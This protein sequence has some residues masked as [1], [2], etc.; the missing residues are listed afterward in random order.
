MLTHLETLI[1]GVI[2]SA[3]CRAFGDE[4]AAAFLEIR[5]TDRPEFG[6]YT[7]NIAMLAA[8]KLRAS[9]RDIGGRL[10]SALTDQIETDPSH[11]VARVELAGPGF[12]NLFLKPAAVQD[13]LKRILA[14][15]E[16]FGSSTLG[17]GKSIQIEFVSSNPT[18]PLTV[19]HGRQAV[20]GDVLAT[21]YGRI[22]YNVQREY[23]FNDEG[24]QIDL[25][26]ESL[27]VRYQELYQDAHEIPENGYQGD[28]LIEV[29]EELKQNLARPFPKFD[30]DAKALFRRTA[31]DRMTHVIK[32]DLHELGVFFDRWFS[33]A[34]LHKAGKIEQTLQLL[35]ANDGV[36]EQE[37]AIWL[38]SEAH[39][40]AKD[41]VLIRSDGRPTYL[42]VDIA[43]HI[44][45]HERGFDYV[46]DVQGADHHAEQTCVK[47]ALR[48]LGYPDGWLSY[49]VHQ[50]VSLKE[51]GQIQKMS[52]R[53]GRFVTLH[54]LTQDLGKDVV[55]YFMISRKPEA[56]LD[57]DLD[58]ARAESSDNPSTYIQYAYTR[59]RSIFRK[60]DS[61]RISDFNQA[62]LSL[63]AE[64]E[65]LNLIKML[66]QFPQVVAH[67]ALDFAPHALAEYG[68]NLS[69]AFHAYYDK[70]RVLIDDTALQTARLALLAAIQG[71]LGECL[72]ILGMDAPEEM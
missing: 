69:R 23:Y 51:G 61:S 35:T 9:P 70:H 11:P 59:I 33:E 14:T 1:L 45:K 57:F 29:A 28:Y 42:M 6:D 68:L 41:S 32:R 26:A 19:G 53:A 40:G 4:P 52:T 48:L 55:R 49:A 63:L 64:L 60:T 17:E 66:D 65:E 43:Y 31:V 13:A 21:L 67:A 38:R 30:D 3:Y 16:P 44:D 71:A 54:D 47:A 2:R 18:G 20:L 50:F 62:D 22:G 34:D 36:Y 56:H 25:L 24:Q 7:S 37:G 27:W 5:P 8:S 15:S 10:H 39:G 46:L 58:L 72:D 12:L